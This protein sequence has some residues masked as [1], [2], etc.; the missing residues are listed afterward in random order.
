MPI[1]N[2][3]RILMGASIKCLTY[4]L[5]ENSTKAAPDHDPL[6][7]IAHN[8][9]HICRFSNVMND[10]TQ[11]DAICKYGKC[12]KRFQAYMPNRFSI[13]FGLGF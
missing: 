1:Q 6:D 13:L 12:V 7:L 8:Q 5:N 9:S 10:I 4:R 3:N 11:D 2:N